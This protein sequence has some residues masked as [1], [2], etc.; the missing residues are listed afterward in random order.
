[1]AKANMKLRAGLDGPA[2]QAAQLAACL[3]AILMVAATIEA[4][5]GFPSQLAHLYYLPV[6]LGALLLSPRASL[7]IAV[8]AALMVSPAIDLLHGLADRPIYFAK[9]SPFD[10]SPSGWVLR[11]I[12]FIAISLVGSRL[13]QERIAKLGE[14]LRTEAREEELKALSRIDKM[15]L[16]G[17]GEIESIEEIARFLLELTD[18]RQ[19][20]VVFPKVNGRREQVYHGHR[21]LPSGDTEPYIAEHRTY[22]EGVAGWVMVHGGTSATS[23]VLADP[24]YARLAEVARSSGF[25]SSAAA[26]IVL[27]GEILGALVIHYEEP[28]DFSTEELR[29]LERIADQAAVAV[30]NARQREALQNMGLETA[31]V[32]SNVIE[33]RDAYTGDHCRRLVEYAGLTAAALHLSAKEIDLIRLG[34]ALHDVGK[35]VV[36]DSILMKPDKLTPDEYA[37]IKQHCYFGGQIC[38]KVPFLRSV[39]DIVYH[40]HEFYNGQGYPDGIAG[41]GIPLGSRIVSV[42]D[43]YDAMTSDR[44]YR[45]AITMDDAL[46]VL[47]KGAGTQWD[48]EIVR[49]FL[50]GVRGDFERLKAA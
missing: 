16:S 20:G 47:Q 44:P 21:R 33:T 29:A 45:E 13:S 39:H 10:L 14:R 46:D 49:C 37:K 42:V 8:M 5:N 30:S 2:R 26:A 6:V 11:P 40:H 7:L 48:P 38:K 3:L 19:A 22:G 32:L 27:D 1:M 28:R 50:Y 36:P 35:I 4:T 18:A 25:R 23:D 34:A 15:I 9:A 41:E 12:A 17:A 31:M 43:A 24:R